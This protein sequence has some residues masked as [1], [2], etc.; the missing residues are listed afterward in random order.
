MSK[1]FVWAHHLPHKKAVVLR[2]QDKNRPDIEKLFDQIKNKQ[3]R[4]KR[5]IQISAELKI[6][7]ESKTFRQNRTLWALITII[8]IT[9]N[10]E[11]PTDQEKY[12]LYND[13]LDAYADKIPNRFTGE[14]RAVR[15]SESDTKQ[16][17]HLIEACMDILSTIPDIP[18][19]YVSEVKDMFFAWHSWRGG[20]DMDPLDVDIAGMLLTEK[21]WWDRHKVSDASGEGGVLERAHIVSRGRDTQDIE[22]AWN[23]IAL[24][25]NEHRI[26]HTHG[27]EYFLTLYPHLSKRVKRARELAGV[28]E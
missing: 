17:A 19:K 24:R 20:Q 1:I 18:M 22:K 16:A 13:I 9:M 28:R 8:Y 21:L 6:P 10:G 4:L 7:L 26:Q 23:W 14:M 11:K 12:N 3:I 15:L 25:P 5:D 2:Y 27:W